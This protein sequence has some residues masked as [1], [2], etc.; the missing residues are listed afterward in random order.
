MNNQDGDAG[1]LE[2]SLRVELTAYQKSRAG[3]KAK[4]DFGEPGGRRKWSFEDYG[5]DLVL[6]G[7]MSG[8]GGSQ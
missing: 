7:Q 6:C 2:S 3:Q 1:F 5:A 8:Y 4:N